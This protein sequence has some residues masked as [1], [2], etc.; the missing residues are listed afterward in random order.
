MTA[1]MTPSLNSASGGTGS[2]IRCSIS[3]AFAAWLSQVRGSLAITTYQAGKVAFVGWDGRQVT[4]LMRQFDKP[5]GLAVDQQRLALA[6]RNEVT[7]FANAP[8]LAPDY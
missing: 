5:L 4:L 6:T 3:D 7:Y 2:L 1:A 8:L